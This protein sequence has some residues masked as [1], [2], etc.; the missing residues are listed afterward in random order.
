MA[1][2]EARMAESWGWVM[3]RGTGGT[4]GAGGKGPG[5]RRGRGWGEGGE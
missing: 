5:W 1:A 3:G 4:G 2:A